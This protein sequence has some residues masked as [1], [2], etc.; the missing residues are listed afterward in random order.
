[1][2]VSFVTQHH[3]TLLERANDEWVRFEHLKTRIVGY[4]L[5]EFASAG[6]RN[7]KFDAVLFTHLIV[8][9]T[10]TR[11]H[12]HH[13]S[14]IFGGNEASTEHTKRTRVTREIR[15]ERRVTLTNKL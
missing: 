15:K 14:S 8:V 6:Y 4:F 13:T 9:F 1:M 7:N 12:V 10:E 2:V 5:S 11:R 3:S